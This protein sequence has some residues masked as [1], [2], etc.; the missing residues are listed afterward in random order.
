MRA[1]VPAKAVLSTDTSTRAMGSGVGV[2]VAEQAA[3]A[4]QRVFVQLTGGLVL[5]A[6]AVTVLG[7]GLATVAA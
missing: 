2:V 1:H 4:G 6:A 3:A 7:A 5:A